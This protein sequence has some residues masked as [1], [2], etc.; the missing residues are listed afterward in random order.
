MTKC[1]D[2][3]LPL[4][5]VELRRGFRDHVGQAVS[6]GEVRVGRSA[7]PED[8][9]QVLLHRT[10]FGFGDEEPPAVGDADQDLLVDEP[11]KRLL[12]AVPAVEDVH[13]QQYVGLIDQ[14]LELDPAV[15]LVQRFVYAVENTGPDTRGVVFGC[16]HLPGDLVHALEPEA[17]D[18]AHDD[19]WICFEQSQH[20][21]AELFDQA[22]HLVMGEIES[23]QPGDRLVG[24]PR[25][26]PLHAELLCGVRRQPCSLG[27]L[28]GIVGDDPVE[29]VTEAFGDQTGLDRADAFHLRVVGQVVGETVGVQIEVVFHAL[30]LELS[31]VLRVCHPAA[32][33]HDRFVLTGEEASGELHLVAVGRHE[34]ACG[35]PRT[36][37]ED[38]LD[39]A[40]DGY[41]LVV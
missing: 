14:L 20:V 41:G 21:V 12:N 13:D 32:V 15:A 33:Q 28:S 38:R 7:V 29:I 9:C 25:L 39:A 34:T 17:A 2:G 40:A 1:G 19:V 23:G 37:V 27:D 5:R 8:L 35:K 3:G 24:L 26:E 6:V 18:L 4:A 22:R 36:G 11:V 30:D 16:A 31:A 10:D